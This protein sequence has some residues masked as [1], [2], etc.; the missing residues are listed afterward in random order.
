MVLLTVFWLLTFHQTILYNRYEFSVFCAVRDS[1]ILDD[2][3]EDKLHQKL[4]HLYSFLFFLS[5]K[6]YKNCVWHELSLNVA[7]YAQQYITDWQYSKY[8]SL[9]LLRQECIKLSN[10]QFENNAGSI[11]WEWDE[12]LF[13][14]REKSMSQSCLAN[15]RDSRNLSDKLW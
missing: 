7:Q 10:V 11:P 5:S 13:Q 4:L 12:M 15:H 8:K 6:R 9:N 3:N 2:L 14:I 1:V